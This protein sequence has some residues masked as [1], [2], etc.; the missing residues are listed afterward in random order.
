MLNCLG[1]LCASRKQRRPPA[2]RHVAGRVPMT[3]SSC[4]CRQE[5]AGV[6]AF[7]KDKVLTLA[8][9][10][11]AKTALRIGNLSP[12]EKQNR[13]MMPQR[14]ELSSTYHVFTVYIYIYYYIYILLYI[15]IYHY[16]YILLYIYAGILLVSGWLPKHNLHIQLHT[17]HQINQRQM[18]CF[19]MLKLCC[20]ANSQATP[21]S[22]T[23]SNRSHTVHESSFAPQS[24]GPFQCPSQINSTK[25]TKQLYPNDGTITF[26]K[27]I[28]SL[29]E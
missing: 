19:S 11:D 5:G 12:H 17:N 21:L 25:C 9:T 4:F 8:K 27:V 15:Y 2:G 13:W 28:S 26:A 1:L 24:M 18:R 6:E 20:A 7:Q 16:I 14:T 22:L 29:W 3:S 23:D 10:S